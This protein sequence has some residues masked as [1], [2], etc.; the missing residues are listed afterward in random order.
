MPVQTSRDTKEPSEAWEDFKNELYKELKIPQ[1][2]NWLSKLL[3]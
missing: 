1:I 2:A 3:T